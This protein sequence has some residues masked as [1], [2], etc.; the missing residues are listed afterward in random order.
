MKER[1]QA[2]LNQVM[3]RL[4]PS[5]IRFQPGE[6]LGQVVH[7]IFTEEEKRVRASPEPAELRELKL[8]ALDGLRHNFPL[9]DGRA[10]PAEEAPMSET[11]SRGERPAEASYEMVIGQLEEVKDV[12]LGNFLTV[13]RL[14]TLVVDTQSFEA[15]LPKPIRDEYRGATLTLTSGDN[16]EVTAWFRGSR[17][18]IHLFRDKLREMGIE[19]PA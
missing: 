12:P 6:T 3:A 16:P 17:E 13:I 19:S 10:K 5:Q 11:I 7:R 18:M 4:E 8:R 2:W 9:D 14:W 1:V 15:Q